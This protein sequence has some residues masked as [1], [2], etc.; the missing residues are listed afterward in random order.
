MLADRP[1]VGYYNEVVLGGLKLAVEDE[2][3]GTV[4]RAAARR[5]TRS[6]LSVIDDLEPHAAIP[7]DRPMR[8]GEFA[9]VAGR[10]SF[11]EA[12]AA[13]LVLLLAQRGIEA[14]P[15]PP[16]PSRARRSAGSTCRASR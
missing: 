3:R 8:S 15:V 11:D 6:M 9:C 4:D 16:P 2:A 13:M 10:G 1:L 14:R 5:M 12:V 7:T